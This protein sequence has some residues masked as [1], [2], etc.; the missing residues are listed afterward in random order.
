MIYP[1]IEAG[2]DFMLSLFMRAFEISHGGV[3]IEVTGRYEFLQYTG[4]KDK[5]GKE[6]YEGDIVKANYYDYGR[7]IGQVLFDDGNFEVKFTTS[8]GQTEHLLQEYY[9]DD[10]R[11]VCMETKTKFFHQPEI[12]GNIYE[13]PKLLK[14]G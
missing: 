8:I 5:N 11:D 7:K 2:E 1:K 14:G 6:I 10:L 4:L 9:I 12:I 3:L 13:N